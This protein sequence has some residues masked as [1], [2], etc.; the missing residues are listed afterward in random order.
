MKSIM[1]VKITPSYF[2][3]FCFSSHSIRTLQMLVLLIVIPTE[4]LVPFH[5]FGLKYTERVL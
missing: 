3:H 4:H 5:L 2:C 1:K